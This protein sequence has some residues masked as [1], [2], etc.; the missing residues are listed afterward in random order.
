MAQI[1]LKDGAVE[2]TNF[3]SYRVLRLGEAPEIETIIVPSTAPPGGAGELG[4]MVLAPA[5]ANAVF[6]ATGV[7]VRRLPIDAGVLKVALAQAG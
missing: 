7:R 2:Q 5:V 1:T 4:A 6:A 3:D